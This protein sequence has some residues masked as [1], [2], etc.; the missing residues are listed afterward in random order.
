MNAQFQAQAATRINLSGTPAPANLLQRKCACGNHTIIGGECQE[1]REKDKAFLQ[2]KPLNSQYLEPAPTGFPDA[3]GSSLRPAQRT[4]R[5]PGFGHDFSKVRLNAE[6]AAGKGED[7][8]P[9]ASRS[10]L[11]ISDSDD[12][13]E[14][15]AERRALEVVRSPIP[16]PRSFM[17]DHG[18]MTLQRS[19]ARCEEEDAMLQREG[20]NV[21]PLTTPVSVQRALAQ[22]GTPL[23]ASIRAF[24]EP[25]FAADF[26]GV[27][28]HTDP[29]SAQSATAVNARAYTVGQDIVFA[30]GAYSPDTD[31]GRTLIAHELM[32]VIQQRSGLKRVQRYTTRGAGGCATSVTEE[33]EDDNGPKAAGRRAHDQI[34]TF[35]LPI[36]NEVRIPRASKHF[37]DSTG[38]QEAGTEEGRADL[39]RRS[40]ILYDIGEIKPIGSASTRGVLEAEHYIRR[41]DQS[42]DRL[43]GVG[44]CGPAGDDDRDFQARVFRTRLRPTFGKLSGVLPDTTVIGPFVG[45]RTRTLKAKTV[46]P[47]A[48]GYWCTGGRSDTYTCGMS[49]EETAAYVDRVVGGPAQEVLDRFIR[50]RIQQPLEAALGRQSLGDLIRLAERRFGAQIR[51]MLRPY[52]GPVADQVLSR[53]SAEQ[54]AQLIDQAVGAEAR[55]IVT[56]LVRLITDALISELRTQLRNVLTELVREA[57]VLLCV[58]VP[59]VALAELLE[60]LRALLRQRTLQLIPVVVTVVAARIVAAILAEL[61]GM[62]ARMA[63]AIGEAL[64]A[65]GEALAAVGRV[66]L[67]ALAAI[68]IVLLCVGV[69]IAAVLALVTVFDPVPGDEAALAA[70]ALVMAGLIPVL[71]RYVATGSTEEQP[72]GA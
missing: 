46:A 41:A 63:A 5:E 16:Q 15:E 40:G 71:G 66:L 6:V 34:Q 48:V 50:E 22:A 36:L 69:V 58:G 61:A 38:C 62:L 72:E 26:S 21:A 9:P 25:R 39:M 53:A 51:Q 11:V 1:C 47:G 70:A 17:P 60:K 59:A 68:A 12:P 37:V 65:I 42:A 7:L 24:M 57:L 3:L 19:C 56:T 35:L 29:L 13:L 28:V 33:D 10:R 4:E 14:R 44:S 67:R 30:A 64:G 27:R 18:M 52:L 45:D 49:P 54:I 20:R 43:F 31:S 55:A 2:R 8:T 32:H 23:S